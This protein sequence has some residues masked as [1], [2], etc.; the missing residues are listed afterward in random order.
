MLEGGPM[1]VFKLFL[2]IQV[3]CFVASSSSADI[4]EWTDN[5]G[6][7]HYINQAPPSGFLQLM[8]TREEPYDEAADRARMEAEQQERLEHDRLEI[9]QREAELELREA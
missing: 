6:L 1:N 4:Y 2:F 7:R 8:I 9:A 5:N 3:S